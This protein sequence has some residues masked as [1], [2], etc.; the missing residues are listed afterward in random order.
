MTYRTHAMKNRY[1]AENRLENLNQ[2]HL[3]RVQPTPTSAKTAV[4]S[5]HERGKLALRLWILLAVVALGM[6]IARSAVG[7]APAPVGKPLPPALTTKANVASMERA[8]AEGLTKADL[9]PNWENYK[10]FQAYYQ[11]YLF[12]KLMDPAYVAEYGSITQSM[13]DDLDR[14]HKNKSPAVRLLSGWFVNG[15]KAIASGNFHPAARVNATLL[16]AH[17]DDQPADPRT[18]RPPVPAAAALLPMVALYQADTNPDGVRAAALQGILRHVSLGA[19]SNPQHSKG[20]AGIMLQLA[21][22]QPPAGRSPE[23]HAYMQRYA[24]KILN[25]LANPATVPKTAE[26]LV[27]LSTTADKP[28]LIAAFAASKL[29]QLKPGQG[30]VNEPSKVL[31]SWAARAASTIDQE[32]ARIAK[33]EPPVAVRDQPAMPSEQTPVMGGGYG[34]D[35]YG[36]GMGGEMGPGAMDSYGGGA[37]GGLEGMGDMYDMGGADGYNMGGMGDAYGGGMMAPKAKPQ[38]PEVIAGRRRINHVLQQLQY[39][40]TGQQ[41]TGAPKTPGGLLVTAT[42]NDKPA[43]D[44]WIKTV[45]DVVTAINSNT[46]DDR[47]KFVDELKLQSD[48]L[49][50]LAGIPVDPNSTAI[51]APGAADELDE[52]AGPPMTVAPASG[53]GQPAAGQPGAVVPAGGALPPGGGPATVGANNPAAGVGPGPGVAVP[54][55]PPAAPSG[56]AVPSAPGAPAADMGLPNPGDDL[57]Q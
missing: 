54:A 33:L 46:L 4:S 10:Y 12:G 27:S 11:N 31:A 50:K 19:V 22:S 17:V 55:A 6:M 29:G 28:N 5:T 43:F 48:A 32:L 8:K 21:E 9:S 26:T 15:G 47:K 20:I 37:M 36:G 42:E 34:G 1:L 3:T 25:V 39:G 40:V 51:A 30:K 57:L 13:L 53:T 38:P 35:M 41:V 7:Q 2:R 14:A 52:L 49:K 24:V 56:A 45:G 16:L 23:A 44:S 18:G